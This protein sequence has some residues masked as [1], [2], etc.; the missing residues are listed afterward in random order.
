[1][2]AKKTL[3]GKSMRKGYLSDTMTRREPVKGKEKRKKYKTYR[4]GI[5]LKTRYRGGAT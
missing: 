4:E 2:E 1:V 3:K 5:N